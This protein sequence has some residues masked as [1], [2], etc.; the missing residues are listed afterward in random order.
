MALYDRIFV[1]EFRNLDDIYWHEISADKGGME[2]KVKRE[3]LDIPI[4]RQ[5]ERT[6]TGYRTSDTMP[7][8][9]STWAR[10]LREIGKLMGLL[11]SLTQYYFR[12]TVINIL[13]GQY[14]VYPPSFS[15]PTPHQTVQPISIFRRSRIAHRH[16]EIP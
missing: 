11:I 12:R 6:D 7:L 1:A 8:K 2:L 14:I 3:K 13:N 4:F 5:P 10:I 9:A 16:S 15:S